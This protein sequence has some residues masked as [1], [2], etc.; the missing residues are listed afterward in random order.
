MH[1]IVVPTIVLSLPID[2]LTYIIPNITHH[3]SSEAYAN[4]ICAS[5]FYLRALPRTIGEACLCHVAHYG[6]WY[7]SW[8]GLPRTNGEA[9]HVTL[10]CGYWRGLSRHTMV[11]ILGSWR[12]LPRHTMV[13]IL[14]RL[15]TAH[16]GMD[17]GILERLATSHYRSTAIGTLLAEPPS[18]NRPFQL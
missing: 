10:W 7:G 5:Y 2:V 4:A 14:E 16:Y 1:T 17:I 15:V 18:P 3:N 9:C 8:R 12:G 6:L 13:W 11:W